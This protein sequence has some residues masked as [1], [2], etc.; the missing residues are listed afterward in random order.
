M[1]IK[2]AS[3]DRVGRFC[4]SEIAKKASQMQIYV[5]VVFDFDFRKDGN[6]WFEAFLGRK[7]PVWNFGLD[8]IES[9][10]NCDI[11]LKCLDENKQFATREMRMKL[12]I[13][14]CSLE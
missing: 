3:Q 1:D 9:P 13:K 10:K 7:K 4:Q 8:R 11:L 12:R 14:T 5:H 6:L 2:K